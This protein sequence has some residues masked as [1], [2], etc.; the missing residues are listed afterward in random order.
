MNCLILVDAILILLLFQR[1]NTNNIHTK[2]STPAGELSFEVPMAAAVFFFTG[3]KVDRLR[4]ALLTLHD[5]E[6]R[7]KKFK[8]FYGSWDFCASF[9][10][11]TGVCFHIRHLYK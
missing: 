4:A 1:T 3:G 6:M 10:C 7:D 2:G 5:G 9:A 11:V 8:H